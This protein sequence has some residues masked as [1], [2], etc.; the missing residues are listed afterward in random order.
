ML[1][2]K[3]DQ[4]SIFQVLFALFI[5]F[6]C[7]SGCLEKATGPMQEPSSEP[8]DQFPDSRL[9]MDYDVELSRD[10]FRLQGD[11]LLPGAANLGYILLNASLQKEEIPIFSTKYLLMQI[12]PN[13]EYGFE[14][15]KSCRLESGEYDCILKAESPQGIIAE[16]VRK[17]SLEGSRDRL[18]GWSQAEEMAFWRMIEEYE[19]EGDVGEGDV[20]EGDVGE[21]DVGEGDVGEADVGEAD[22]GEGDEREGDV[23]EEIEGRENKN[24][25]EM[26]GEAA[27]EE[28]G[29]QEGVSGGDDPKA[30]R[31]VKES[32]GQPSYSESSPIALFS[33]YGARGDED[34]I[35]SHEKSLVGSKSSRKYHR[36]DC[37]F[38]QKIKPENLISFSG[39]EDA[40]RE[41][42][43]P[44]KVCNP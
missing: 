2:K 12:E 15:C 32:L 29:I 28:G 19:R 7:I 20:G 9:Q 27:G 1:I 3:P 37:R 36:P 44:C 10:L 23:R 31:V 24:D 30:D 39:V 17:V 42:Y 11:L 34:R 21:G 13:R 16:E 14:I 40:R 38:A 8:Y 22:V 41:G 35:S 43:L 26:E 4:S 33:G 25:E 5:A 18:E 6:L